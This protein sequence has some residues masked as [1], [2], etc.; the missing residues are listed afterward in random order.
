[1][2]TTINL[3]LKRTSQNPIS[4]ATVS[5]TGLSPMQIRRAYNLPSTGGY[6]TIAII[7]AYDCPTVQN[8]FVVF[9]M[10][11]GLPTTNLE[12]HKM[13]TKHTR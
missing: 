9:S 6:G 8:D 2:R 3:A 4:L 5:P 7:D 11:Y 1:M 13:T 12:I 10:Q